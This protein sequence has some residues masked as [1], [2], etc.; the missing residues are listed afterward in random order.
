[1]EHWIHLRL[2]SE[3]RRRRPGNVISALAVLSG[4]RRFLSGGSRRGCHSSNRRKHFT[5]TSQRVRWR[6]PCLRFG[7]RDRAFESA[8]HALFLTPFDYPYLLPAGRRHASVTA[9]TLI[10]LCSNGE[11]ASDLTR[12]RRRINSPGLLIRVGSERLLFARQILPSSLS[13]LREIHRNTSREFSDNTFMNFFVIIQK[14]R[15]ATVCLCRSTRYCRAR[16]PSRVFTFSNHSLLLFRLFSFSKL[17]GTLIV[18]VL[19]YLHQAA[20]CSAMHR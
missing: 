10:A 1:M 11:S 4:R 20:I 2:A 19:R 15:E 5:E 6:D 3:S 18:T 8:R 9:T 17:P 12:P 13:T 16:R 14:P 7:P